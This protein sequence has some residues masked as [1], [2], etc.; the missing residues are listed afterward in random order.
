MPI[1][2]PEREVGWHY[3]CGAVEFD[4]YPPGPD[5]VDASSG[6]VGSAWIEPRQFSRVQ[7]FP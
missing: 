4:T 2:Q 5:G 6:P 7:L 1:P 3:R